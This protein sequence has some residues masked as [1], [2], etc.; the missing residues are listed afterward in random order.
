MNVLFWLAVL[1]KDLLYTD[2][3]FLQGFTKSLFTQVFISL[4]Q[5]NQYTS[6]A[7]L[8]N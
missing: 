6:L 4:A 5:I 8:L 1:H 2:A 3:L 7:A